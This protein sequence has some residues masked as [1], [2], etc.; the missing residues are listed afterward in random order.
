MHR[1]ALSSAIFLKAFVNVRI[2]LLT[3][4]DRLGASSRVRALQFLP[5][6][7]LSLMSFVLPFGWLGL[8]IFS[9]LL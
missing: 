8:I 4:Y 5:Y 9:D 2:L 7:E 3:R 1:L 6:F